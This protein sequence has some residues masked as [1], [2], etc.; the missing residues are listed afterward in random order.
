MLKKLE[1]NYFKKH[2]KL[3]VEF[4]E[5]LNGIT[6]PNYK[7]KSTIL[8]GILFCLGG[9]RMVPGSR[10][11]TRGTNAGFK[12]TLWFDIPGKGGYIVQRTK[13]AANLR[14][15]DAAGLEE[16]V[17][18]GTTP[19][20]NAIAELLGMP[21]RRFAQIK[22]AKQ[23][24]ADAILKAG[25]GELFKIVTELTGLERIMSVLSLL[26]NDLKVH[27][28][29]LELTPCIDMEPKKAEKAELQRELVNSTAL[30]EQANE[31][32]KEVSLEVEAAEQEERRLTVARTE[33][34]DAKRE[35]DYAN[36]TSDTLGHRYHAVKEKVTELQ[37]A[38]I[39]LCGGEELV[40]AERIEKLTDG[41]AAIVEQERESRKV[42]IEVV[43]LT[44][45]CAGLTE[46]ID[47]REM[48]V[49]LSRNLLNSLIP[50][51][52]AEQ[53]AHVEAELNRLKGLRPEYNHKVRHARAA[54]EHGVCDGCQRPMEDFNPQEASEAVGAAVAELEAVDGQINELQARWT[55][56]KDRQTK[57]TRVQDELHRKTVALDDYRSHADKIRHSLAVKSVTLASLPNADNLKEELTALDELLDTARQLLRNLNS[58][59]AELKTVDQEFT[60]AGDAHQKAIEKYKA[61]LDS[62]GMFHVEHVNQALEAQQKL[63]AEVRLRLSA[64]SEVR[65]EQREA[66]SQ[67]VTKVRLLEQEIATGAANNAKYE[68][69]RLKVSS[70]DQ[71]RDLIRGNRD[72]YS[73]QV[74]NVFMASAS[75]FASTL[76]GGYM[77]S[78]SRD[79][80]G[81]FTFFEEGFEMSLDEGSGAQLAIIGCAV[82][83]AL[84]DAAQCP[85]DVILMDEPTADMDPE[86]ALAFSTLLAASGKQVI[87]VSHRE[88]DS[89]VFNHS[90]TL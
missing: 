83:M 82:Q 61:V 47:S 23:K 19:V 15:L 81:A 44:R 90:I 48:E 55:E 17:A 5:G 46:G 28:H 58:A 52:D 40:L 86:H 26:D 69:A 51:P 88:L 80:D 49:G 43:T 57:Y 65:D 24:A 2:E 71:L 70:M 60:A 76:T 74:W 84:A 50:P 87:M 38:S 32:I 16:L 29:I 68:E 12:Q 77:E 3:T 20:N 37:L 66:T 11:A 59:L 39:K 36:L 8:L 75:M 27:R 53:M 54:L 42:S 45:E 1:L 72:R 6:G 56:Y 62:H 85:L 33:M 79:T 73:K 7:G 21:L 4:A 41:R 63:R 78:L 31:S 18:S 67:L 30:L 64:M 25:S 14:R 10:I 34:V 13:T 35:M 22:Y 9:S 89:S